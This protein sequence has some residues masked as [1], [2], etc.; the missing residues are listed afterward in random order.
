VVDAVLP[1]TQASAVYTEDVRPRRGRGKLVVAVAAPE[2]PCTAV[3][4]LPE[5]MAS[6]A[7]VVTLAGYDEHDMTWGSTG[8]GGEQVRS[9]SSPSATTGAS[10]G[11]TRP[12]DDQP[13]AVA[14]EVVCA[15]LA[16][17][18]ALAMLCGPAVGSPD[19]DFPPIACPSAVR[20]SGRTW[21]ASTAHP[22]SARTDRG[23]DHKPGHGRRCGVRHGGRSPTPR[24]WV[25]QG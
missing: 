23:N 16:I 2:V 4:K 18:A 19:P 15:P 6:T 25:S 20:P 9:V 14:W 17:P 8:R 12:P 24:A 3:H 5:S 11:G 21:C 22:G 10:C 1:L 7:K 13:P